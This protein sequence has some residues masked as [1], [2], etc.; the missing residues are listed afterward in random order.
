MS[1]SNLITPYPR[2]AGLL[3]DHQLRLLAERR[4]MYWHPYITTLPKSIS[5]WSRYLP[6]SGHGLGWSIQS[7]LI[8]IMGDWSEP[9][10]DRRGPGWNSCAPSCSHAIILLETIM[11]HSAK[12]QMSRITLSKL[13]PQNLCSSASIET[14]ILLFSAVETYWA[15]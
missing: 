9:Q 1:Q 3:Y 2:Q 8:D 6:R 7:T 5:T 12:W 10:T 11:K 15:H 4:Y 14:S 13:R